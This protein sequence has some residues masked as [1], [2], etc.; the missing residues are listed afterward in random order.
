[1]PLLP[2]GSWILGL[3]DLMR[4]DFA[5]WPGGAVDR[6]I[7]RRLADEEPSVGTEHCSR[8]VMG[9]LREATGQFGASDDAHDASAAAYIAHACAHG[10]MNPKRTGST[11][12]AVDIGGTAIPVLGCLICSQETESEAARVFTD[13]R[14]AADVVRGY[15]VPGWLI[16][17]LRRH[18]VGIEAL[19]PE[20]L[21]EFGVRVEHL[22]RAV[23][24]ATN[25]VRTYLMVFGEANPHFHVLIVPRLEDTPPNRRLGDILKTRFELADRR[26]SL[27]MVPILRDEYLTPATKSGRP[28]GNER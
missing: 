14:W 8:L 2:D 1:M 20:E 21:A 28:A 18:A 3:S 6:V 5:R 17:R 7:C 22:A 11:V 10:P 12:A 26:A 27:D 16:L 23:R 24:R 15:E 13:D 25:A 9:G 19:T 4:D